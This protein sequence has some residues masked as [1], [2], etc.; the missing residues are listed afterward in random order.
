MEPLL[1]Q[2]ER[3]VGEQRHLLD[4][5]DRRMRMDMIEQQSQVMERRR[6]SEGA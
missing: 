3:R 4:D 6:R 5:A 2:I 1:E